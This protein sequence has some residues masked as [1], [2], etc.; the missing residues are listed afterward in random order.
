MNSSPG[1]QAPSNVSSIP[2]LNRKAREC[3]QLDEETTVFLVAS[4][5]DWRHHYEDLRFVSQLFPCGKK[6][7]TENLSAHASINKLINAIT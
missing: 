4:V 7:W 1:E 5:D 3:Q 6:S 2:V